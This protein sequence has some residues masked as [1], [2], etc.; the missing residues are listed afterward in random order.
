MTS[1]SDSTERA[2]AGGPMFGDPNPTAEPYLGERPTDPYDDGFDT[3]EQP[4]VYPDLP[5]DDGYGPEATPEQAAYVGRAEGLAQQDYVVGEAE[6]LVQEFPEL[7]RSSSG[8]ARSR[9]TSA[10]EPSPR[11]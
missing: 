11:F 7:G 1:F 6:R 9:L 3:D 2:A 8:F 4:L 10:K 5:P